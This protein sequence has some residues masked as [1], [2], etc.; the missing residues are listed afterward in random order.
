MCGSLAT[1][2]HDASC[3]YER[4]D[5][6]HDGSCGHAEYASDDSRRKVILEGGGNEEEDSELEIFISIW[7][8]FCLELSL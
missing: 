5:D 4:E 1:V 8:L 6:L 2:W 3:E 7:L